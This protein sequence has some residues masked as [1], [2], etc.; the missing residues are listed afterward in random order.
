MIFDG[1][2]ESGEVQR[3]ISGGR[4]FMPPETASQKVWEGGGK[5]KVDLDLFEEK[6][7]CWCGWSRVSRGK[8]HRR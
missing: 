5:R 2:L 7:R 6:K 1:K 8:T 3:N 4:M